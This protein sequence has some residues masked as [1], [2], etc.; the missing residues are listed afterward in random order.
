MLR[1]LIGLAVAGIVGGV[2]IIGVGVNMAFAK[3]VTITV[4][5]VPR[6][7]TVVYASVAE[8]LAS[9]HI[10]LA[11]RDQVTPDLGD[12]VRPNMQITVR[13]ARP[14]ELTLDGRSGT[15][16][17]TATSVDEVVNDLGLANTGANVS[18]DLDAAIGRNGVDL[19]IDTGK[20]VT[21]T[22]AGQTAAVHSPGRVSDALAAAGLKFDGDDL[23]TPDPAT[24][25]TAGMAIT[26]V[27][28]D[29]TTIERDVA[30]PFETT[31]TDDPELAQGLTKVDT[32]G[33]AGSR[34]ETVRQTAHDG[35]VV[36]EEVTASQV[37]QAPVTQVQRV[38][39]KQAPVVAAVPAGDAQQIAYAML[40]SRGWGDDQFQCLVQL[41]NR[42]SG[43]RTNAS[44]P[45]GAYGIPQA[46]PGSKMA[47]A[48]PDWQ[49]N[50]A[51]QI[52]WGLG[53]ISGRYGT[54]C[55]AWGWFTSHNW[56]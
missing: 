16:W 3:T 56:Y 7:V 8:V 31:S 27:T 44:N 49:T 10:P 42:E 19:G 14:V 28:V 17:T 9:Q 2:S 36:A 54:P 47:S 6:D 22:A 23:V 30:I 20:D 41:W 48:G 52:T 13:H 35:Q 46:L 11:A 21:V 33:V 50:P 1:R 53:Y 55:G 25:L 24:W 18:S 43:W 45:S 32:P 15:Y 29:V 5:G 38:G 34:H 37:T 51:T 4:D 26:L 40:Q 12:I 39:T